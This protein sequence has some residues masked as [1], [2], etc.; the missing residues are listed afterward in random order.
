M[1]GQP[2]RKRRVF[3]WVFMAV[4]VL[5]IIWIVTGATAGSSPCQGLSAHACATAADIGHGGAIAVRG[6]RVGGGGRV[7]G[8]HL[9]RLP[10]GATSG[11]PVNCGARTSFAR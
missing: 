11:C 8:D 10:P 1:D 4:Q 7:A 3:L 6:G 5:F 2:G 9:R